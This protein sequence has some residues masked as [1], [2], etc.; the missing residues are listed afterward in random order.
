MQANPTGRDA[1]STQSPLP[2]RRVLVGP[3]LRQEACAALTAG[4]GIVSWEKG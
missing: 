2:N 1:R 3:R 4:A